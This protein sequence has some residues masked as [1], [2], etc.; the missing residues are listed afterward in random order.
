MAAMSEMGVE[1][2]GS[3][4]CRKD[5]AHSLVSEWLHRLPFVVWFFRLTLK[6]HQYCPGPMS[7]LGWSWI[8]WQ[9]SPLHSTDGLRTGAVKVRW[10]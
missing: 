2:L 4:V 10:V 3:G 9:K 8:P 5:V 6:C 7:R 1:G